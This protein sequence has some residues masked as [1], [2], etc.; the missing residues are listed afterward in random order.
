MEDR[1]KLIEDYMGQALDL[2]SRI[3]KAKDPHQLNKLSKEAG[4]LS[5]GWTD[6]L[7]FYNEVDSIFKKSNS[8][9][10]N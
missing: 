2:L 5:E 1:L 4:D 10:I 6:T 9:G 8:M 3:A 7:E